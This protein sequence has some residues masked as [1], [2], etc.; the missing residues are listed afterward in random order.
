MK[1]L[2][3]TRSHNPLKAKLWKVF[4]EWIRR[5]GADYRGYVNCFSCNALKHWK[6]MD[7]GHFIPKSICGIG[8]YFDEQN[9]NPQCTRCNRYM[10]SNG[11][12]YATNLVRKY[13][14]QILDKLEWKKNQRSAVND[15]WYKEMIKLYKDKIALL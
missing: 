2:L 10:H 6:E 3:K 8:L 15:V 1:K 7:A 13:G 14:P 12:A 11:S 4:S 5:R 9:V